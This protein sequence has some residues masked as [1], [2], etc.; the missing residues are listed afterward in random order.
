MSR[1]QWGSA[2]AEGMPH[3]RAEASAVAWAREAERKIRTARTVSSEQRHT[4]I[5]WRARRQLPWALLLRLDEDSTANARD[6][7][8][9]SD[10]D[11]LQ[12]TEHFPELCQLGVLEL[13]QKR[14]S[15]CKV[16]ARS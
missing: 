7:R 6:D 11:T 5:L 13:D 4:T 3:R 9:M 10:R 2:T 14:P 1:A 16:H 15:T 8:I 12:Y